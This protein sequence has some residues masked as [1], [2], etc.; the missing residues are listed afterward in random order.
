MRVNVEWPDVEMRGLVEI[1]LTRADLNK[2]TAMLNARAF[3]TPGIVHVSGDGPDE[4][5]SV[6]TVRES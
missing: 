4:V 1:H 5:L 3:G 6:F 2:M